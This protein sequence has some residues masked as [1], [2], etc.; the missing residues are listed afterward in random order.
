M[1]QTGAP[2]IIKPQ[3]YIGTISRIVQESP[4][5]KIFT[6]KLDREGFTFVPGQN[7]VLS[8]PGLVNEQGAP[9]KRV[10]SIASAPGEEL[11][12]CIAILPNGALSS[13]LDALRT[14]DTLNVEGPFGVYKL[15][16]PGIK[17]NLVAGGT[18]IAPMISMIRHIRKHHPTTRIHLHFGFR[19]VDDFLYRQE[20][21]RYARE[22]PN[23]FKLITTASGKE[24][25]WPRKGHIT[26]ALKEHIELADTYLC[27]PHALVLDTRKILAE[28][29]FPNDRVIYEEW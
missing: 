12:L 19:D 9:I 6:F 5:V 3:K 8:I 15:R 26:D 18:G 2:G 4:R 25:D 23:T 11:E 7:V 17:V 27:G 28:K 24:A 21:E 1:A 14:G 22:T 16:D 20:L 10:Y 29:G 13:K